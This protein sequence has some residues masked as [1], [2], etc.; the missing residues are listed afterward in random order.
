VFAATGLADANHTLTIQATGRKNA[1]ASASRIVVDAFDV[2]T[3]GRRYE[4]R[5]PS[6]AYVG[7][8]NPHNDARVWS[9]GPQPHRIKRARPPPSASPAPGEL[10]RLRKVERRGDCQVYLDGVFMQEV[11]LHQSYPIEDTR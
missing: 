2:T 1:A 8:W 6:I 7:T 3:P 9:E 4:E 10:D 5:D 11:H